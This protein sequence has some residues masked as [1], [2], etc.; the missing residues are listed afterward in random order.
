MPVVVGDAIVPNGIVI[1]GG[2][3]VNAIIGVIR[4]CITHN[5]IIAGETIQPDT[6][7]GVVINGIVDNCDI[8]G[9]TQVDSIRII[10]NSIISKSIIVGVI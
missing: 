6:S 10:V 4:D 7:S 9:I 5:S 2:N 3:Q 8:I 1:A